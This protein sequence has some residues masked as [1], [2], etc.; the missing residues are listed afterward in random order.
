M[1]QLLKMLLSIKVRP[2]T[3]GCQQAAWRMKKMIGRTAS[4]ISLRS[5]CPPALGRVAFCGLPVD[6]RLDFRVAIAG[7]VTG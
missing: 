3:S 4:S 5:I 7:V 6:Q 2:L 1:R